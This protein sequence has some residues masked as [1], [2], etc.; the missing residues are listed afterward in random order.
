MQKE[1]DPFPRVNYFIFANRSLIYSLGTGATFPNI[2][3]TSIGNL[4]IFNPNINEKNR[5]L[6]KL[7]IVKKNTDSIRNICNKKTHQ[8]NLLKKSILQKAF[9]GE[10]VKD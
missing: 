1:K 5:I 7:D 9:N 3:S 2:S 6:L 10:L 4:Q 8:L